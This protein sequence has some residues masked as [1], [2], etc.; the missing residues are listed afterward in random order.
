[1][2]GWAQGVDKW[3]RINSEKVLTGF[4]RLGAI[5]FLLA[6]DELTLVN[7]FLVYMFA[8]I[9]GYFSYLPTSRFRRERSSDSYNQQKFLSFALRVWMGSMA[10]ILLSRLD[11]VLMITLSSDHELGLYSTAATVA[12]IPLVVTGALA[13]VLLTWE[14]KTPSAERGA[15]VS[16]VTLGVV[17]GGALLS[18]AT[19]IWW[20]PAVFG[21]D[22]EP[23]TAA[24]VVLVLSMAGG[25]PG[26]IAGS[27]MT[28]R[29]HPAARSRSI[30]IA[31]IVNVIL[32]IALAPVLGALGASLATAAG[33]AC[34]TIL[35]L[36]QLRRLCGVRVSDMVLVTWDDIIWAL[37][38]VS[39]RPK[40]QRSSERPTIGPRHMRQPF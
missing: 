29:G 35:S 27:I 39:G 12:D 18:S 21:S 15:K 9:V 23:G 31:L 34:A 16:R 8:P 3:H 4:S 37:R 2:R 38:K 30:V 40:S 14:G 25:A 11:Q 26:S 5:L 22:F 20:F 33:Q 13:S 17:G 1:M 32:L 6:R 7:A 10:G 24:L 28:A 19:A 36:L